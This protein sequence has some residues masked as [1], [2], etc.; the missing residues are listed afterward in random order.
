MCFTWSFRSAPRVFFC[1]VFT[2]FPLSLSLSHG[3]FRLLFPTLNYLTRGSLWD[4]PLWLLLLIFTHGRVVSHSGPSLCLGPSQI[5]CT[6]ES[7][8]HPCCELSLGR[9]SCDEK[10]RPANSHT[11]QPGSRSNSVARSDD[12]SPHNILITLSYK[13]LGQSHPTK[14]LLNSLPSERWWDNKSLLF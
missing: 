5:I 2:G 9:G 10:L 13:T 12:C 11:N 8:Y 4:S 7:S 14:L 3:H 6:K 1:Y